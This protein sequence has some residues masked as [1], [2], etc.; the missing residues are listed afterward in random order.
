MA[1]QAQRKKLIRDLGLY[2]AEKGKVL[3]QKEYIA[4]KDVPVKF[5]KVREIMRSYSRALE[6][7]EASEPELWALATTPAKPKEVKVEAKEL[8]P[9]PK[10]KIEAVKV[11]PKFSV[12]KSDSIVGKPAEAAKDE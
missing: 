9:A 4:A 7:V 8:T 3:T 1:N 12:P 5:N 6:I 11:A 10:P 2:F